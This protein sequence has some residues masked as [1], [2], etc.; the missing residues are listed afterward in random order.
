M[1]NT[2]LLYNDLWATKSAGF[3]LPLFSVKTEKSL[4]IGDIGDLYP[5]IDWASEHGQKII[6]LLPINDTSPGDA[7]PYA[8]ISTY[9]ANPLYINL[10]MLEDVQNSEGAKRLLKEWSADGTLDAIKESAK[11]DYKAVR[12]VKMALLAE[13]FKHF[14][15]E[16]LEHGNDRSDEFL[17]FIEN[18]KSWLLDYA[19]FRVLKENFPHMGW[20]EWPAEFRYRDEEAMRAFEMANHERLLFYKWLQ[21]AFAEQWRQMRAYCHSKDV[22]LMGDVSFYP[23]IDSVDVWSNTELFQLNED[24]SL[25]ATSGAPP[26]YFN[27][28]GQDWGTPLY[29]WDTM[30]KDSFSWWCRRIERVCASFD[31][32]RLDHF[33]GFE[34]YW[35][36]PAG[37][38]ASQGSWIKGPGEKL[39][40]RILALTLYEKLLIP[41]AEDLG[42]ITPE[43]HAL[44]RS[45]GI[46]GYKT[47][48]FGWGEG[49]DSG[50]ASGYRYP[51]DYTEDFLATTGT[52]DTPTMSQWWQEIRDDEKR[53]LLRYL[54]LPD[55]AVFEEMRK[56]VFE[57]LF[58]SRALFIVLPFQDVLGLGPE[59]R[60]NLPGTF[61]E[62][63]WS[64]RMPI[65]VEALSSNVNQDYAMACRFLKDLSYTSGR[66]EYSTESEKTEI[67]GTLPSRGMIQLKKIGE[68]FRIWAA[69]SG[70]PEKLIMYSDLCGEEGVGMSLKG[71]LTDGVY[72]YY[73]KISA[74]RT[75]TYFLK[76]H[77]SGDVERI[78]IDDCLTVMPE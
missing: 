68:D 29:D 55:N 31:L 69:V 23:G 38:K 22:Y 21:W 40:Q 47:F 1:K 36:V 51:E 61:G 43:V 12:A 37:V 66:V 67:I 6:Q 71:R 56:A 25:S 42:D 49:E 60:I 30:A 10:D 59:E 62:H 58:N 63:N 74:K 52:H 26:D 16:E 70:N 2:D 76:V 53:E 54:T 28:D 45:L 13:G 77:I 11:V 15:K 24:L 35:K 46:A 14:L 78:T 7:S 8:A 9:A 4:G 44:R 73:G 3:L 57:K 19:V 34:A 5:L 39:L 48:I 75:G 33:R 41:L 65:T 50:K 72:L 17:I 20:R 64:W 18:E 32:Y 27:P